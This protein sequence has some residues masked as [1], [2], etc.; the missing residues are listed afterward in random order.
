MNGREALQNL[1]NSSQLPDIIF[2]DLNMPL[3][4]GRQFLQAIKAEEGFQNIPVV[5]LSTSSDVATME[6]M[7]L[8]G[9][10]HF[11]TKP[12]KYSLWSE[13]LNDFFDHFSNMKKS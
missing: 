13:S 6:D 9:I 4:N 10:H 5:V 3:M 12:D 2:L 11:I 8:L 7:K 1:Q